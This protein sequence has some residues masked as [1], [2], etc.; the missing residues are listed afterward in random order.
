MGVVYEAQHAVTHRRVA[1]KLMHS[2]VLESAPAAGTRFVR[3]AQAAASIGHPSIVDVLDAG[4]LPDGALYLVFEYLEGEDLETAFAG[5]NLTAADMVDI[6]IGTLEGLAAAHAKSFIHRDI[7][8]ANIFL[9]RD[10]QGRRQVKLLDFGIAKKLN[11]SSTFTGITAHG[12]IVGT[13]E[14]MSPEQASALTV[15]PRTD[16]WAVGAVLYR[17]FAGRPPFTGGTQIELVKKII[18][19]PVP[20]LLD[21]RSD[22]PPELTAVIDRALDRDPAKRWPTAE[23]MR[24][25]I[26]ACDPSRIEV[27]AAAEPTERAAIPLAPAPVPA[28]PLPPTQV[29]YVEAQSYERDVETLLVRERDYPPLQSVRT[30]TVVSEPPPPPEPRARIGPAFFF[31]GAMVIGAGALGIYFSLADSP[32]RVDLV[33]QPAV[34]PPVDTPS[35]APAA[36]EQAAPAEP[37]EPEPEPRAE[38]RRRVKARRPLKKVETKTIEPPPPEPAKDPKKSDIDYYRDWDPK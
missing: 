29:A 7:K 11:A 10:H 14:Y 33:A 12:S 21:A 30:E 22:L 17:A 6:A 2:W 5:G 26:A 25:A 19:A 18:C 9:T 38:K 28:T 31:A 13:L 8:P 36:V 27:L 1:V 3:E 23:A 32:P 24:D 20:S 37:V 16:L 4:E 15:D 35:E 34:E